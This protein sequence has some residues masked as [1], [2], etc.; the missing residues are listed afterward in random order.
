M[1]KL[2]SFVVA[3]MVLAIPAY[4]AVP[5]CAGDITVHGYFNFVNVE[6]GCWQF[7]GDNGVNY[8]VVNHRPSWHDGLTGTI[9]ADIKDD[10][11]T[12]CMVGVVVEV[13][14]FVKDLAGSCH[15]KV[16][17]HEVLYK[18]NSG[19]VPGQDFV[20]TNEEDWCEF[21]SDIN[22]N[23]LP[24]PPCDT[25]GI[26]FTQED[27][28]VT[29][30]GFG[31]NSCYGINVSCIQK[32]GEDVTV[33]VEDLYP[34]PNCVCLMYTVSPLQVVKVKKLTGAADFVH[35]PTELSCDY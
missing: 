34:G 29:A 32:N 13:C 15:P 17:F 25:L 7:V 24:Q 12:F 28:I 30:L 3:V 9:T 4:S 10:M 35:T 19:M 23:I 27:A 11:V 26:D 20:I 33:F 2:I 22:S 21:W 16:A 5:G 8:E 1:M 18:L 6:G 31:N 14:E